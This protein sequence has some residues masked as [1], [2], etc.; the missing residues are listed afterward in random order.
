MTV[1]T[2]TWGSPPK[3]AA[4]GP[5]LDAAV[6]RGDLPGPLL[7]LEDDSKLASLAVDVVR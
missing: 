4:T 6:D 3:T 5:D 7:E 1:P 2:G